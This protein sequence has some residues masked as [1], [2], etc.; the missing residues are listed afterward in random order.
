MASS[1]LPNV[2]AWEAN[3]LKDFVSEYPQSNYNFL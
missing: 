3:H 1:R 2:L